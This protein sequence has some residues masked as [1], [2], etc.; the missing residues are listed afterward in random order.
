MDNIISHIDISEKKATVFPG[1]P[2]AERMRQPFTIEY[3]ADIDLRELDPSIV[4]TPF[5]LNVIPLLWF[6]GGT[7]KVDFMDK[8]LFSSLE[9]VRE[10]FRTLYPNVPWEGR[11]IPETLT[12][13]PMRKNNT[14]LSQ[15]LFFSGGVDSTYSAL[16]VDPGKTVLLTVRGHD[17][18]LNN[19]LGW[20][21]VCTQVDSFA[22][23]FAFRTI[24]VSANVF[25][26]LRCG[27][28]HK[29]YPVLKPWYGMVQHGLGLAGLAFP[30]AVFNGWDTVIFSSSVAKKVSYNVPWGAHPFLEPRLK[31]SGIRVFAEGMNSFWVDKVQFIINFCRDNPGKDKPFMRVCLDSMSGNAVKNCVLCE[32]CLRGIVSLLINGEDPSDWGF[33]VPDPFMEVIRENLSSLSIPIASRNMWDRMYELAV[34][35]FPESREK[36]RQFLNWYIEW[37][38]CKYPTCKEKIHYSQP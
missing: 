24:R 19:D 18:A 32:K 29:K 16:N 34:E 5:L 6:M 25:G 33:P 9:L 11:L 28:I 14:D 15:V 36:H 26:L 8:D 17:I 22:S 30:P 38:G 2:L 23:R 21:T 3:D 12:S 35:I 4:I 10:G 31:V 27:D 7:Y 13:V 37:Y 1:T 20:K